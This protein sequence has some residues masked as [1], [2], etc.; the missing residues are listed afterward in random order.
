MCFHAQMKTS[1]AYLRD[2]SVVPAAALLLLCGHAADA[3]VLFGKR[4]VAMDGGWLE[5]GVASK[6]AVLL[7]RMREYISELL[8][9]KIA[10]PRVSIESWRGGTLGKL[11]LRVLSVGY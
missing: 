1:A 10:D 4:R 6:T 8:L 7:L 11:L 5:V 9:E 2:T 3:K